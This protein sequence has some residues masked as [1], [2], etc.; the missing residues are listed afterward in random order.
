MSTDRPKRNIIRKKYDIS[1]GMPWCEERLVRKVLFL[2]LREF[3]DTHRN[4]HAHTHTRAHKCKSKNTHAQKNVRTAKGA[5]APQKNMHISKHLRPHAHKNKGQQTH[6]SQDAQALKSKCT[7]TLQNLPTQSKLSPGKV[8]CTAQ[9]ALLQ[10]NTHVL[11][12]TSV[13]TR[14]LRSHKTQNTL[15][16]LHSKHTQSGKHTDR[17]QHKHSE[18]KGCSPD[19]N[20][21][22]ARIL[23]SHAPARLSGSRAAGFSRCRSLLSAG[24]SWSWSLQ[25]CPAEHHPSAILGKDDAASRRPRL[26]AQRKF[27]HSPPGHQPQVLMSSRQSHYT[28]NLAV[29]TCLTRHRPKTEDFLSFLCLRGSAAVPNNM[30][31]LAKGQKKEQARTQRLTSC[32]S[33]NNRRAAEGQKM[34]IFNRTAAVQRESRSVRASGSSAAVGSFCPLTGRTLRRREREKREEEQQRRRRREGTT[35]DRKDRSNRAERYLLRPCQ[36]SIQVAMVT[37]FSEQRTSY[38]RPLPSKP[39]AGAGSRRFTRASTKPRPPCKPRDVSHSSRTQEIN[40]KC[41]SRHHSQEVPR[42]RHLPVSH[43]MVSSYYSNPQTL[44]T[45]QNSGT[46]SCR[47][48]A[49]S[50]L[51]NGLV[52]K[53][54]PGQNPG[55]LRLS[56]RKRGLPPDTSLLN[57]SVLDRALKKCR[58]LQYNPDSVQKDCCCQTGAKRADCDDGA[59]AECESHMDPV[60][61]G[62]GPAVEMRLEEDKVSGEPAR[63]TDVDSSPEDFTF[64]SICTNSDLGPVSEEVLR[65]KGLQTSQTSSTITKPGPRINHAKT[66]TRATAARTTGTEPPSNSSRRGVLR[67]TAK[68]TNRGTSRAGTKSSLH[69]STG[70]ASKGAS[71]ESVRNSAPLHSNSRT[72][73][74]S[75]K[76]LTQTK[77]TTSAIQT[78]KSPRIPLKR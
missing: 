7:H 1:E 73:K 9:D 45:L 21:V 36:L 26:Q 53:Q 14:T 57:G 32:L 70:P 10:E 33:T 67:Q 16:V 74:G 42:H 54:L 18:K 38:V 75:A 12:K 5:H 13:S 76:G 72:S 66:W 51:T 37:R 68:G 49:P 59:K 61:A 46:N 20:L 43:Q 40:D 29:V 23:R 64:T 11:H 39:G 71:E 60:T 48:P 35:E 22:P 41:L 15:S 31:F 6:L 69:C 25:A 47:N 65:H 44:C 2:S 30:A 27:A 8:T 34:C 52:V 4:T 55:V 24:P 63:V 58:T 19:K 56:R 78:R 62:H 50:H 28:H 17:N 3:R 77:S